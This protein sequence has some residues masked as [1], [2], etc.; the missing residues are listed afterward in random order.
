MVHL[1]LKRAHLRRRRAFLGDKDAA[2]ETA[3]AWGYQSE[4]QVCEEEPETKNASD[5][6]RHSKPRAIE[7]PVERT[8]VGSDHAFDEST[9]VPFH[10][11][12]FVTGPALPQNAR[13]HQ[14]RKRQGH[15]TRGENGYD[16]CDRKFAKNAA[17]Q[18]G[19]ENQRDENRGE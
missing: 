1:R 18:A 14:W 6:D 4:R 2:N 7:K 11:R 9:G 15:E 13:A 5:K 3:V 10:P 17:E 16:D 8:A 12:A 19:D